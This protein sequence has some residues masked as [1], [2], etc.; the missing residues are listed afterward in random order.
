MV[1]QEIKIKESLPKNWKIERSLNLKNGDEMELSICMRHKM[2]SEAIWNDSKILSK[3][4]SCMKGWKGK[5]MQTNI[6]YKAR[7]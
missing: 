4:R 3:E 2:V 1:L 7:N 5:C 6:T